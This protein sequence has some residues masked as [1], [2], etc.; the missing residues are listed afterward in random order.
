[1]LRCCYNKATLLQSNIL[2]IYSVMLVYCCIKQTS[3]VRLSKESL[4][5]KFDFQEHIFPWKNNKNVDL[6][7]VLYNEAQR[8]K[9]RTLKCLFFKCFFLKSFLRILYTPSL[10]IS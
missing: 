5:Y 1:M 8:G 6:A 3:K 10:T 4:R 9:C 2:L 7:S